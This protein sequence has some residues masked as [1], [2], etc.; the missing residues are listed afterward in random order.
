M[1]TMGGY[2]YDVGIAVAHE[3]KPFLGNGI[4]FDFEDRRAVPY[5]VSHNTP[6]VNN[7]PAFSTSAEALGLHPT[8]AWILDNVR[9]ITNAVLSLP[10][11][12]SPEQ[13]KKIAETSNWI[14]E[15]ISSLPADSPEGRVVDES[16]LNFPANVINADG[17]AV[18]LPDRAAAAEHALN[19]GSRNAPEPHTEWGA[20]ESAV[21]EIILNPGSKNIP[22]PHTEWGAIESS[23][24]REQ[25]DNT[26]LTRPQFSS[27]SEFQDVAL[28]PDF[29]YR[30]IRVAALVTVRAI[31][32]RRPLSAVCT[33]EEFLQIW[34]TSWRVP[35]TTWRGM[36][37]IFNWATVSIVPLSHGGAHE[38]FARTMFMISMVSRAVED[39]GV[40][41]AAST[42]AMRLQSWLSGG[43]GR[44]EDKVSAGGAMV[45]KHGFVNSGWG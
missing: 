30:V 15:Q 22:E 18:P 25:T 23:P 28:R 44:G 33:V 21:A 16:N 9:F 13:L 42:A 14:Y 34:T 11:D 38:R 37:G 10:E 24:H 4:G 1:L 19:P 17:A 20:R 27:P 31:R 26:A 12:A 40:F 8:A 2:S 7:L 41:M 35:L 43:L 29:I 45:E 6:L 36:I 5:Q 39:W 32:D 3:T